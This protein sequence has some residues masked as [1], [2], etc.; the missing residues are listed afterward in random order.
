MSSG[1]ARRAL[2]KLIYDTIPPS[3]TGTIV[4]VDESKMLCEVKPDDGGPNYHDV[5]LTSATDE[6]SYG[7][8]TIPAQNSKIAISPLMNNDHA[9]FVCKFGKIKKWVLKTDSNVFIDIVPD[10]GGKVLING[11]AFGG[12]PKVDVVVNKFNTLESFANVLYGISSAIA[13]A[14]SSSPAIPVT[15]ATLAAFFAALVPQVITPSTALELENPKVK[16]G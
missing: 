12:V 14:G 9:Y 6:T 3:I 10:G 16:H 1:A 11:D 7:M 5:R 8:I 4:S 2:I 15:N 13:L